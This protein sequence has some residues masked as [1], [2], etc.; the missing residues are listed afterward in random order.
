M[1]RDALELGRHWLNFCSVRGMIDYA[2]HNQ[3]VGKAYIAGYF[4]GLGGLNGQ[5]NNDKKPTKLGG[6]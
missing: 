1:S 5:G 2:E 3:I 6:S 4:S